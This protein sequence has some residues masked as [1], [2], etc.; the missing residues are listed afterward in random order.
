MTR[1]AWEPRTIFAFIALVFSIIG[2]AVGTGFAAWLVWIVTW[3]PWPIAT[4]LRR[5]DALAW[6]LLLILATVAI[7]LISL[8][9]VITPRKVKASGPAGFGFETSSGD[10]PTPIATTQVT[11]TVAVDDEVRRPPL[12]GDSREGRRKHPLDRPRMLDDEE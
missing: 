1:P 2:A 3:G 10:D 6:A 8:G 11:T 9:M 12:R 7:V 5:I 4:A